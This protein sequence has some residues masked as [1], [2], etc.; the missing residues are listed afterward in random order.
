MTAKYLPRM[1]LAAAIGFLAPAAHADQS[2][3]D[4]DTQTGYILAVGPVQ[5][6]QVTPAAT[7]APP[8]RR[9]GAARAASGSA[10]QASI[11]SGSITV[12]HAPGAAPIPDR[13]KVD[14]QS[15]TVIPNDRIRPEVETVVLRAGSGETATISLMKCAATGGCIT[16]D[17]SAFFVG[18]VPVVNGELALPGTRHSGARPGGRVVEMPRAFQSGRAVITV[19]A[20]AAPGQDVIVLRQP[21]LEARYIWV[22]YE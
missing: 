11:A 6:E 1:A 2:Q 22:K 5:T 8:G 16:S 7:P 15:L 21:G 3:V 12:Q 17:S 19:R 4:Y 18:L 20:A 9:A 14:L 10:P 13:D